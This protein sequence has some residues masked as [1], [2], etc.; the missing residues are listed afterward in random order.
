MKPSIYRQ[1]H[2]TSFA[3]AT[4]LSTFLVITP[5]NAVSA[6]DVDA[7]HVFQNVG[8][9]LNEIE[10]IRQV[11]G[12]CSPRARVFRLENAEP[13]QVFF[14][15]QTLFRKCNVL[16]QEVAGVSRQAPDPSPE[17][18]T[19]PSDVYA[20]IDAARSQLGYVRET[21]GITDAAAVPRF[22]R[23]KKDGDVMH[24]IVEAGY[25]LNELTQ[26]GHDWSQIYDRVYQA[27]TYVGGALPEESRYPSLEG[28]ACC[29][30]P[31]DVYLHML[32]TM[33]AARPLAEKHDLQ[34]IRVIAEKQAEGGASREVVY[35][36]T[37]T[38]VSDLGE[39]TLRM[40]GEDV[41][42]PEYQRPA[43]IFPSHVFQLA[44]ALR[45]Q[46]EMLD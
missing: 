7:A 15:A 33:E 40:D 28:F 8:T 10:Q 35:D 12:V 6:E 13:R 9:L 34:L 23:N 18:E 29:K 4:L 32:G 44:A 24:D 14:Q 11:M 45:K 1:Y 3:C 42:G 25:I 31:Q 43:R 41:A 37:T 26:Q 27:V 20:M 5:S 21:L 19:T 36:L 30:M 39:L 38:L 46:V 16:A 22:Q 17:D 2:T